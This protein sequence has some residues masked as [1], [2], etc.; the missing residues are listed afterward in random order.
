MDEWMDG[1][2]SV[3]IST[4]KARGAPEYPVLRAVQE[5]GNEKKVQ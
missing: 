5:Y 3:G 4:K 2:L 1:K